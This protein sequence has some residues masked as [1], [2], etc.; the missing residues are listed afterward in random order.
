MTK[1]L[2]LIVI[3]ATFAGC[4]VAQAIPSELWGVWVVRR[5]LSTSRISCWGE[6]EA[7]AIL[8]TKIEYSAD[9]FRWEDRVARH[10]TVK[11]VVVTAKQFHDENSGQSVNSSQ[12]TFR[13]LGIKA[14]TATQISI[15]HPGTTSGLPTEP[16]EMPGDDVLIKDD[17]SIIFSM[18]NLYFEAERVARHEH[19][20][21]KTV[22]T[23]MT[24]LWCVPTAR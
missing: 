21:K 11:V 8:G 4:C 5:E 13:Q 9:S 10:P 2:G 17:H 18:C 12:V 24:R 16:T 3:L 7:R 14:A 6:A 23:F 19:A 22:R 15:N 20:K 1:T